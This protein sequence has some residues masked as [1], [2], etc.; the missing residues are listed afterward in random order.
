MENIN[1]KV[2]DNLDKKINYLKNKFASDL[3]KN[4][5]NKGKEKLSLEYSFNLA[6]QDV[7]I[8]IEMKNTK[9]G[10]LYASGNDIAYIEFGTGKV[11]E[12]SNYPKDKLPKQTLTFESPKNHIQNTQGWVYYYENKYTKRKLK[13]KYGWYHK[14]QFT[15][16][17]PAG[18]QMY[19]TANYLKNNIS[20]IAKET[21]K[22]NLK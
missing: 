18:K 12:K 7:D 13:G 5:L 4:L 19:I 14:K 10:R 3:T 20:N 17:M 15:R 16:G 8:D 9:N 21:I 1:A 11:G 6:I 2:F 22:E